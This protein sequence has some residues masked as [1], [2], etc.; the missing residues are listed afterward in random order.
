MQKDIRCKD[1]RQIGTQD[2]FI[3]DPCV[4]T[5]LVLTKKR[6]NAMSTTDTVWVF[7]RL[8]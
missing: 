5:H 8:I 7:F 4:M 1:H 2:Q 3:C 6:W